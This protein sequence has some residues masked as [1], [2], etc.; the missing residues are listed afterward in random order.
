MV[1]RVR[2][3]LLGGHYHCRIFSAKASDQTFAKMGEVV[4]RENEFDAFK[5]CMIAE[6]LP[7]EP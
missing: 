1:F 3:K 7:E 6:F 5:K 2:Y 4:L